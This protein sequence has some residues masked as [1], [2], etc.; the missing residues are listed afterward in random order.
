[1][2]GFRF[3]VRPQFVRAHFSPVYSYLYIPSRLSSDYTMG[4][5]KVTPESGEPLPLSASDFRTYNRMSEQMEAFV[6]ILP[7][8]LG[9]M[10]GITIANIW[11]STAI[12]A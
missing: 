5:K 2:R 6:S 4:A 3:P 1:M 7:V 8:T 9:Y 11:Y 10:D 12:S